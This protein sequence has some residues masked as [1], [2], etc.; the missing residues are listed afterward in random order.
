MIG[1]MADELQT[2]KRRFELVQ[3]EQGKIEL[4][5]DDGD[6]GK[7]TKS[8]IIPELQEFLN[9]YIRELEEERRSYTPIHVDE[10]ASKLAGMYE[11]S[12]KSL[13]GRM[14]MP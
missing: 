6:K 7:E 14:I 12:E 10:I 2:V 11:K 5:A 8:E 13:I 3:S 9:H 1:D 4:V